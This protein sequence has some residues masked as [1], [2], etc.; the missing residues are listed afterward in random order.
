VLAS[1]S[2]TTNRWAVESLCLLL[3]WPRVCSQMRVEWTTQDAGNP[4][5]KWGT[6]PGDYPYATTASSSSYTVKDMCGPPANSIGWVEPGTFHSAVLGGLKPGAR[7]YYVVGD[8]VRTTP[9]IEAQQLG[10]HVA[11]GQSSISD[12]CLCL[13]HGCL[14]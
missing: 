14:C 7:Y 2:P 13:E 3:C 10:D 1:R 11:T 8:E 5:V 4:A 12:N 9:A 6:A